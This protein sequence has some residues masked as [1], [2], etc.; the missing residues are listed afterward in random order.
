MPYSQYRF[1]VYMLLDPERRP[2]Y[3]GKGSGSRIAHHER[4]AKNGHDCPKCDAIRA[5]WQAGGQVGRAIVFETNDEREALRQEAALIAHYGLQNLTNKGPSGP[6]SHGRRIQA[7]STKNPRL[8]PDFQERLL[9]H[10][11]SLRSFCE[12]FD[13]P[14]S[15]IHSALHPQY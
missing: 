13:V 9:E 4:E 8:I 5:I 15:T 3:I 12:T 7:Q 10:G 11:Y 2:F 1:Y 6:K 14:H